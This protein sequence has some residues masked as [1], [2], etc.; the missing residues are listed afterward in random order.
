MEIGG[1]DIFYGMNWSIVVVIFF[2]ARRALFVHSA[3]WTARIIPL[4]D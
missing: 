1:E 3:C 2:L 4:E